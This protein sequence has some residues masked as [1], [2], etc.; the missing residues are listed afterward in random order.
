[1]SINRQSGKVITLSQAIAYTHTY[2]T[3]H[4]EKIKSFFVGLDKLNQLLS[5]EDCIG[6][7]IYLGQD[8]ATTTDNMVLVA[9]DNNQEDITQGVILEELIPCPSTCPKNS[10]L[11]KKE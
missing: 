11:I 6:L 7:R 8:P 1:M 10:E 2:Q 3:E 9:V 5:Q 4:P